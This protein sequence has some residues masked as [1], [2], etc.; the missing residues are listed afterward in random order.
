MCVLDHG[1]NTF[2]R[3]QFKLI[4]GVIEPLIVASF[5]RLTFWWYAVLHTP[6]PPLPHVRSI[7]SFKQVAVALTYACITTIYKELRA[8][9]PTQ[10]AQSGALT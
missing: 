7:D 5:A 2:P 4:C 8:C 3:I 1:L 10:V 6:L 9:L